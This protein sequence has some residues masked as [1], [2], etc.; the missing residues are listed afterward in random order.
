[1]VFAKRTQL[2]NDIFWELAV[3]EEGCDLKWTGYNDHNWWQNVSNTDAFRN[4]VGPKTGKVY[5]LRPA[6]NRVEI[7]PS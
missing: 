3:H 2:G 5:R 7:I 1:M 6:T 4:V